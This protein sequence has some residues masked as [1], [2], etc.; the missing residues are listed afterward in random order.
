MY[1]SFISVAKRYIDVT[2][3]F[4]KGIINA[5]FYKTQNIN[6]RFSKADISV[7]FEGTSQ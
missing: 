7:K 6:V 1:N 5:M 2:V 3:R 4:I